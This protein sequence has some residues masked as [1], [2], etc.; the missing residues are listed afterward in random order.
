[1]STSQVINSLRQIVQALDRLNVHFSIASIF[2]RYFLVSLNIH[3]VKLEKEHRHFFSIRTRKAERR[4]AI[5][6]ENEQS[7]AVSIFNRADT[8]ALRKMMGEAYS[9]LQSIRKIRGGAVNEYQI[10]LATLKERI[11][12]GRN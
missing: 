12:N 10:K 3:R 2:R 7:Q 1:M 11:R 8:Q 9:N 5:F 6:F 4:S